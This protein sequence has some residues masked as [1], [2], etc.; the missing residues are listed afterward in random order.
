ML[1]SGFRTRTDGLA[2][3]DEAL[4]HPV[5]QLGREPSLTLKDDHNPLIDFARLIELLVDPNYL[6]VNCQ[7]R[8]RVGKTHMF[9]DPSRGT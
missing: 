2:G 4:D 5:Q 8:G 1:L 7:Q 6:R 3:L 9:H